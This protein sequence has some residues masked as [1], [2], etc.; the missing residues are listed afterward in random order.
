MKKTKKVIAPESFPSVLDE[1]ATEV[2]TIMDTP[3]GNADEV[4]AFVAIFNTL[5]DMADEVFNYLPAG[6]K[7]L[8]IDMCAAWMDV[9]LL[10]G[11]SPKILADIL[12]RTKAKIQRVETQSQ[13]GF[14]P[15]FHPK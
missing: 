13:A 5:E 9:G 4:A 12:R 3:P 2:K 7:K 6:E 11:K 8:V 15:R 1:L 10:L 14:P